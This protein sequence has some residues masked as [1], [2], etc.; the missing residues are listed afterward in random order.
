MDESSLA[1]F[2]RDVIM[3][4]SPSV[5][6]EQQDMDLLPQNCSGR[7]VFNFGMESSLDMNEMD[8][9]WIN[10]QNSLR[11]PTWNPPTEGKQALHQV[12]QTP[13]VSS[14]IC[15]G[16]EA[17]QKSV[18]RWNPSQKEHANPEQ[19]NLSIP[20]QDIQILEA[21]LAPDIIDQRIEHYS[22]DRILAMLLSTCEPGNVSKVV[23][24]FPSADLLDSLMHLFFRS[25]LQSTDAFL[26]LPTFR[27]QNQLPS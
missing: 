5:L 25:E 16:A 12:Q 10:S 20:Y 7:D 23:T 4:V 1:G 24:S 19:V 11:Q 13:D 6:A 9:G 8:F 21:R 2:L 22:R 15:A 17:Y 14:G 3:P 27:P 26:H 18:W